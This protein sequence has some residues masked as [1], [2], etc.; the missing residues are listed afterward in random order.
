MLAIISSFQHQRIQLE[1]TPKP[2]KVVLDYK[3]LEYFITTKALTARQARQA[4]ILSQ[5]NFLI[6]Y[7]PGAINYADALT[8]RKQDLGNYTAVKILLRTQT[9]LR[10]EYLNPQIQAELSI[11]SLGAKIYPINP[12]G[13]NLINKLLQ[14]N[15]MAP[16]LQ[17][18]RKKAKNITSLWSLKNRLLKYQERLVV[19]EEQNLWTQLIA[20]AYTQVST[21]YPGKNKTYRIIGDRYYQPRIVIDINRYI[22]NCNDCRRSIILRDKT[23][24]LLKPLLIPDR[25]Q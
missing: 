4:D 12:L 19:V 24:G 3:A 25:P 2:I 20:K 11:D 8:R 17:E 13:L 10:L 23:L 15:Y 18:Y 5:F 1:G 9:L 7:R 16:S 22:W 6:I 21:A 14:I